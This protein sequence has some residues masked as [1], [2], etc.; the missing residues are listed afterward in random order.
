MIYC[1]VCGPVDSDYV[2]FDF[3]LDTCSDC[4]ETL[5]ISECL[6]G[7][8]IVI[9]SVGFSGSWTVDRPNPMTG[10]IWVDSKDGKRR[11]AVS[12]N[13]QVSRKIV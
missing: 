5:A 11:G 13:M 10:S 9:P 4:I 6:R 2:D 12:P 1:D 8:L 3:E 7:D